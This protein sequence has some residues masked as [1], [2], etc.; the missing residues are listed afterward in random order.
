VLITSRPEVPIRNGFYKISDTKHHNFILYDIE[1]AI[2]DYNIFVFLEYQI[3]LISQEW[4]L[5]ASWPSEQALRRLVI[6]ANGLFIW[7]AIAYRF[8]YKGRHRIAKRLSIM[9]EGSILIRIPEYHLNDVYIK[10]IKSTIYE[11]DLEKDKEDTYSMLKQVLGT[12]IFLYSPLS[13]K[14]LSE[15]LSLPIRAIEGGLADLHA[16]LDISKDTSRALRLYYPSFCDFLLNNDRCSDPNFWVDEKQAHQILA[17]SC[18][19]LM[20]RTL[21]KNICRMHAPSSQA[22]Q[23]KSSRL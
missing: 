7:A 16:I 20:F 6:N 23:V 3:G 17:A 14:S 15:L 4:C 12:I 11:E 13:T 10:V 21:K 9:L 1:A 18:I 22:S 8:I 19:Q 5:G 2:M